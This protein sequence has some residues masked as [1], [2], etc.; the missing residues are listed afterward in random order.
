MSVMRKSQVNERN[1][2]PF[3]PFEMP[4][5][6]KQAKDI[7]SFHNFSSKYLCFD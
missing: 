6:E 3:I 2:R 4:T 7:T 5:T 1:A